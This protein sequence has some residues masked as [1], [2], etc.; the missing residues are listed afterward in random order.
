M[1]QGCEVLRREARM[2][3]CQIFRNVSF[4]EWRILDV[5]HVCSAALPAT[6][7]PEASPVAFTLGPDERQRLLELGKLRLQGPDVRFECATSRGHNPMI[8]TAWACAVLR[9]NQLRPMS[10]RH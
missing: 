1:G 6:Q 7:R 3:Q 2:R 8:G 10:S 4:R 5:H 9:Q